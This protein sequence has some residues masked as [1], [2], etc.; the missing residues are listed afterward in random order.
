MNIQRFSLVLLFAVSTFSADVRPEENQSVPEV[1]DMAVGPDQP[2]EE[3]TGSKLLAKN[4][5]AHH[6][7]ESF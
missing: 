4:G 1:Q 6:C 7:A 3:L 2:F 5:L